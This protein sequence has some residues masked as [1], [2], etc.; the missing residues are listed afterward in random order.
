MPLWFKKLKYFVTKLSFLEY[1]IIKN[2]AQFERN[3]RSK[4]ERK[5]QFLS[6]IWADLNAICAHLSAICAH[7]SAICVLIRAICVH[8]SAFFFVKRANCAHLSAIF[9]ILSAIFERNFFFRA[10]NIIFRAIFRF[11]AQFPENLPRN[12]SAI[13]AQFLERNFLRAWCLRCTVP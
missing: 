8:F 6:T 12:F 3:L 2:C 11:S 13:A 1:F 4:F 9:F 5:V 10:K 7:L